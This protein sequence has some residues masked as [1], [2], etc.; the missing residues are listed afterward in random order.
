MKK[1]IGRFIVIIVFFVFFSLKIK[2]ISD[3][4]EKI[5]V[6]HDALINKYGYNLYKKT[7]KVVGDDTVSGKAFCTSF[8][9]YAPEGS[10]CTKT[11]WSADADNNIK[12]SAAIGDLIKSIRN[13]D[14]TITWSNYYDGE[15]AINSFLYNQYK[16]PVNN[17]NGA[18]KAVR[19]NIKKYVDRASAIYNTYYNQDD[20]QITELKLNEKEIEYD[21]SQIDYYGNQTIKLVKPTG[22]SGKYLINITMKCIDLPASDKKSK[23]MKCD[24]PKSDGGLWVDGKESKINANSKKN[25]TSKGNYVVISYDITDFVKANANK[26]ITIKLNFSNRRLHHYAQRYYCGAYQMMTPNYLKKDYSGLKYRSVKFNVEFEDINHPSCAERIS[27]NPTENAELY[28]NNKSNNKYGA[29]LLNIKNSSCEGLSNSKESSC[30]KTN[31]YNEWVKE[32]NIDGTKYSGL[33]KASMNFDNLVYQNS[34][35]Q[36][37]DL[38]FKTVDLNGYFGKGSFNLECSFP[39]IFGKNLNNNITFENLLPK[40]EMTIFGKSIEFDGVINSLESI[41]SGSCDKDNAGKVVNCSLNNDGIIGFQSGVAYKYNF[42]SSR[43]VKDNNGIK[44]GTSID[45]FYGYGIQVPKNVTPNTDLQADIKF[46]VSETVFKDIKTEIGGVCTYSVSDD[47]KKSVNF[48]TIDVSNPFNKIDGTVRDTG[49]N[50]CGNL[51]PI[52]DD[53]E[54]IKDYISS[55]GLSEQNYNCRYAGDLNGNKRWDL[56]DL[57]L[58]QKHLAKIIVLSDDQLKYADVDENGKEKPDIQDATELQWII[59]FHNDHSIGDVNMDGYIDSDDLDLIDKYVA[60]KISLDLVQRKFANVDNS[61]GDCKVTKEDYDFL[62]DYLR[63]EID[64]SA[65]NNESDSDG[66]QEDEFNGKFTSKYCKGNNDNSTV[67]KYISDRP[68]SNSKT[69]IYSFLLTPNNIKRIRE[70]NK[71][72]GYDK[73]KYSSDGMSNQFI[74]DIFSSNMYSSKSDG[75][76]KDSIIKDGECIVDEVIKKVSE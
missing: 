73:S 46:D 4:P 1:N 67:K 52:D 41:S 54:K 14:G 31:I 58:L 32:I 5:K 70:Y 53:A 56:E 64:I 7:Y 40:L 45:D 49:S 72:N 34:S 15:L 71:E 47:I 11:D 39:G 20:I 55:L 62:S 68:N 30:E 26:K 42:N 9:K 48:R 33:C 17:V 13:S 35:A 8:W 38:V 6:T 66:Y 29:Q 60:G 50:W 18:P 3:F 23:Q 61:D 65:T 51:E 76:C 57:D 24:L 36:V 63:N 2:A 10:V 75:L 37:G 21:N 28:E 44:L 22:D 25:I 19:D 27:N 69:P 59:A 43:Y 16:L 74:M 12:A